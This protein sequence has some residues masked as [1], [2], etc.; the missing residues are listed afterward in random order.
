MSQNNDPIYR[1]SPE[2]TIKMMVIMLGI[3]IAGGVI[4]FAMWDYWISAP[5]PIVAILAGEQKTYDKIE[6]TGE[7]IPVS[8]SFVESGDLR[9]LAF[10]ALPGDPGHNPTIT[11]DVGDKIV[12]DVINAGKSFHSFGVTGAEE[13]AAGIIPGTEVAHPNNP[14]NANEGGQSEFIAPEEGI[15]YYICTV[16]GHRELG[17]VGTIIV[18]EAEPPKPAEPKPEPQTEEPQE[19]KAE[20]TELVGSI[21]TTPGS[22]AFAC[23]ADNTCYLPANALV[24]AGDTVTWSNDDTVAHT[25]TSGIFSD[26]SDGNFDTGYPF[27]AGSEFSYTF[28]NAGEYPYYCAVHPHMTGIVTVR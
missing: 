9:N 27:E 21:S 13:G 24:S 16:A 12:F 5:P 26:G 4:F 19:V 17:M 1:T 22:S 7:E 11:A 8:L 20:L 10:N 15:F 18:G 25:V 2:R 23:K 3:C 28:E 6:F 14:L